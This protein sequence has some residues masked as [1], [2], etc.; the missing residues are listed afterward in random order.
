MIYLV[1]IEFEMQILMIKTRK[2]G[3][4]QESQKGGYEY[5]DIVAILEC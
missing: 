1:N 2:G 5:S 3:R 4:V